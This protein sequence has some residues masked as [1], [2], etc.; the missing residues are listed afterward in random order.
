MKNI[1]GIVKDLKM[2]KE[3]NL[4]L[5]I[6]NNRVYVIDIRKAVRLLKEGLQTKS[7]HGVCHDE[8][9]C[10]YCDMIRLIDETFGKELI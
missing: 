5:R 2:E 8:G 4:S 6:I 7:Q 3:I 9:T 1:N 10:Y